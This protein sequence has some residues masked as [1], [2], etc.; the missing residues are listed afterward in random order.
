MTILSHFNFDGLSQKEKYQDL[1]VYFSNN[2]GIIERQKY[3]RSK[4]VNKNAYKQE[5]PSD[6]E[7]LIILTEFIKHPNDS[8]ELL[9]LCYRQKHI[10]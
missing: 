4:I 1:Y 10:N 8:V 5:R 2:P 3:D 7:S 9:T 6:S